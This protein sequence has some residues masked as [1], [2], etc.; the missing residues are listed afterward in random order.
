MA[1]R[2]IATV[3][4]VCHTGQPGDGVAWVTHVAAFH[5][6]REHT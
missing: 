4:E 2:L 3:R 1:E 6:R 5:R